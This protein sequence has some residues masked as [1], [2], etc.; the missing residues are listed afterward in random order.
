LW[1]GI[2]DSENI[3]IKVAETMIPRKDEALRRSQ[4]QLYG[5]A[6]Y[7]HEQKS[8]KVDLR[9]AP[10]EDFQVKKIHRDE[11]QLEKLSMIATNKKR[12]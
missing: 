8:A 7:T 5:A 4:V 11:R 3:R 10:V 2:L 6:I 12:K 1:D 9:Q